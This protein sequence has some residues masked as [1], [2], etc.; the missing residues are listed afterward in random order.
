MEVV[1]TLWI[2]LKCNDL[3]CLGAANARY[4]KN[5]DLHSVRWFIAGIGMNGHRFSTGEV[6]EL[7]EPL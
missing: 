5:Y 3:F 6:C 4:E 2:R 7:A 1:F